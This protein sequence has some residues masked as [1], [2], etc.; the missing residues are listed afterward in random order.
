MLFYCY[1]IKFNTKFYPIFYNIVLKNYFY[2]IY[3][4]IFYIFYI[5]IY[6]LYNNLYNI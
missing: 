1:F 6:I 2:F 3:K 4:N 5:Y